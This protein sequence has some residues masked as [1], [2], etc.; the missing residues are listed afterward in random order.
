[1]EELRCPRCK[2]K[3]LRHQVNLSS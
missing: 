2:T 1:M 3:T